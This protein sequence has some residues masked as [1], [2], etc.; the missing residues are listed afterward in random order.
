MTE[1]SIAS[2]L[3]AHPFFEGFP[4]KLI[5]LLATGAES[6]QVAPGQLLAR[7]GDPA[8]DFFLIERGHV[9]D[10]DPPPRTRGDPDS[11]DGRWGNSRL[12]LAG[13]SL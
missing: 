5:E 9:C 4:P 8:N 7:E 2:H 11:D 6:I 1:Q 13:A 12:V 10:R 3:T